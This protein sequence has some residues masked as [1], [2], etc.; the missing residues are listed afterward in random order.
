VDLISGSGPSPAVV[1]SSSRTGQSIAAV[2]DGDEIGVDA[3][4]SGAFDEAPAS[5]IGF[6][7]TLLQRRISGSGVLIIL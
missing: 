7:G 3:L 2:T 1:S 4:A 6:F 5:D